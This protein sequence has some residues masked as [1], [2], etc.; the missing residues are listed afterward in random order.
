MGGGKEGGRGGED[1]SH[2]SHPAKASPLS[3]NKLRA[4]RRARVGGHTCHVVQRV[5][6]WER[7]NHRQASNTP[8]S[9]QPSTLECVMIWTVCGKDETKHLIFAV[10]SR[11]PPAPNARQHAFEA[12]ICLGMRVRKESRRRRRRRRRTCA[13]C[14]LCG[15]CLPLLAWD[16]YSLHST[17]V[18]GRAGVMLPL[19]YP[20]AAFQCTP[21]Y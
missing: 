15:W 21:Y 17:C 4:L 19:P 3:M 16:R 11:N 20:W 5:R 18:C 10:P 9:S 14:V 8:G 6:G 12:P 13:A 7:G 1:K 2:A